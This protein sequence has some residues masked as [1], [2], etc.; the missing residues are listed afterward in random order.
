MEQLWDSQKNFMQIVKE[1]DFVAQIN[2]HNQQTAQEHG[3]EAIL[4]DA[5]TSPANKKAIRQVMKVVND[6]TRAASGKAPRQI[7]IEFARGCGEETAV[8]HPKRAKV[9]TNL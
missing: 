7:A 4:A 9:A 6:I 3:M 1:P 2:A 8:K 5:Y